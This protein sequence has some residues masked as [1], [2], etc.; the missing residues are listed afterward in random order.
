MFTFN[1]KEYRKLQE[2]VQENKE[3]IAKHWNVDRVLA[4]FGIKVLGRVNSVEELPATEGEDYG[5]GYLVGTEVPYDVYVWTRANIDAGEPNPYWLNIGAISIVGPAGPAGKSITDASIDDAGK[6]TLV[7]SDGTS[8]MVRGT[9]LIGPAGATGPQGSAGPQGPQGKQGEQGPAGPRGLQGPQGPAGAFNIKGTLSSEDLLPDATTMRPGDAYLVSAGA[10]IYDLYIITASDDED[11]STYAWQN[12]G[13]LGAGT[14]ITVAGSAVSEWNADTKLDKIAST[15]AYDRVYCV[16]ANGEQCLQELDQAWY[17]YGETTI[18]IRD[19]GGELHTP[20][21][22]T[23]T[24]CATKK[25]VDDAISNLDSS[26]LSAVT[27]VITSDA[28]RVYGV[29]K[30]G[31]QK[32][33][34]ATAGISSDTLVIRES[35]GNVRVPLTPGASNSA[36]SKKYVDDA[37]ANAF[38]GI[39][40]AEGGS[41]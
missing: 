22:T 36:A 7:F 41:Y 40:T 32:T 2:Q 4:D 21:P 24:S 25:Y 26:K 27:S 15:S 10:A 17:R 14:T 33:I 5:V 19:K 18:P 8:F 38:A 39:A 23:D 37:I 34:F 35:N 16:T 31:N 30:D 6:M 13:L 12:T 1:G 9:A 20:T 3:Q 11:T 29:D 28:T